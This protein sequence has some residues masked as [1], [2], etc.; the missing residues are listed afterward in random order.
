MAWQA[1][2]S[3]AHLKKMTKKRKREEE[4]EKAEETRKDQGL[5]E[6]S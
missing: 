5:P 3:S 6:G 4:K 2:I 1:L